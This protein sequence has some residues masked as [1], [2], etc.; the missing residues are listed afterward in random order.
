M[1]HDAGAMPVAENPE[2]LL[3]HDPVEG[4]DVSW[5]VHL[6]VLIAIVLLSAMVMCIRLGHR[7]STHTMENITLLSSQE[8]WLRQQGYL[9]IEKEPDAWLMPTRNG[10]PRVTKPPMVV[11]LNMLSWCDL[12]PLEADVEVLVFRARLVSVVMGVIM[13]AAIYWSGLS[14]G[15]TRTAVLGAIAA[16]SMWFLQRQSRTASYDIHMAA[17]VS[18]SLAGALWAMNPMR[19]VPG[20]KR[21]LLGWLVCGVGLAFAWMSKGPLAI[22]VTVLPLAGFIMVID[23]GRSRALMGSLSALILATILVVPWHI[24]ALYIHSRAMQVWFIEFKASR[25]EYQWPWY[26]LGLFGLIAPWTLW[27]MAGLC[28]PFIRACGLRRRQLLVAWVWFVVIFVFFSIPG[29]KQ[30]RYILPIIPATALL[31]SQVWQQ[32]QWLADRGVRDPGIGLLLWVH[33]PA[34]LLVSVL[35]CPFLLLQPWLAKQISMDHLPLGSVPPVIACVSGLLMVLLAISGFCLH[36]TWR[37]MAAGI[38]TAV[39]GLVIT[40]VVWYAY[41]DAAS[42]HHPIRPEAERIRDVVAE[43]PLYYLNIP[44]RDLMVNEEFLFY[45]RRIVTHVR[46]DELPD[47]TE[48][49]DRA[50]FMMASADD[51]HD[52]LMTQSGWQK[53]DTFMQDKHLRNDLWFYE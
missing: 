26:Y 13:L 51:E 38:S 31:I 27:L 40:G 7:D 2:L 17:W 42:G 9:D 10:R 6:V 19:S 11:W 46:A 50:V 8:T 23:R 44:G 24:Y 15:D 49:L 4:S 29:A 34:L 5:R 20:W 45:A 39:W 43:R 21:Q 28:Q 30:Q 14:L 53:V 33:W 25:P 48:Q 3:P 36:L 37:P 22:V 18:L 35:W 16:G 41:G 47:F 32:H 1:K 12:E 52:K